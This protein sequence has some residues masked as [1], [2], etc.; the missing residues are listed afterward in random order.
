MKEVVTIVC[1]GQRDRE[2]SLLERISETHRVG[3]Y[4]E[5]VAT[6]GAPIVNW[7]FERHDVRVDHELE[8]RIGLYNESDLHL[9]WSLNWVMYVPQNNLVRASGGVQWSSGPVYYGK[10]YEEL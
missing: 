6:A 10:N 4:D 2:R 7:C 9:E 3:R 1:Q 5:L 8:T